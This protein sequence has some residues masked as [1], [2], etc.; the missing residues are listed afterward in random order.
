MSGHS[1]WHSIKHK[2]AATDA[3]RGQIFTKL[4][5]AIAVTAK[6][7][8]GNPND[9]IQLRMA[10][11]TARAANMPK[12]NIERAIKR[13][14]GELAGA[15][16]S[17]FTLEA[18]GPGN[19]GLMIEVITDN[20]NRALADLRHI[21]DRAGGRVTE[22][23]AVRHGFTQ[24]GV[25]RTSLDQLSEEQEEAIMESNAADYDFTD[26]Q[27][28]V[29]TERNNLKTVRDWLTAKEL[30]FETAQLEY[31]AT[32]PLPIDPETENKILALLEAL[33]DNEDVANVYTNAAGL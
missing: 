1:K 33:D 2:K 25:L 32:N 16:L 22:Q 18:I 10:V 13:G 27:L 31:V 11:E 17:E 28:T 30:N 7:G 26:G 5:K 9:N 19:I 15:I 29:Q 24:K 12:E 14:T 20:R 3:K 8:G 21:V 23:G 4:A 6:N